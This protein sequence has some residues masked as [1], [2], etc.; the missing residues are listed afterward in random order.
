MSILWWLCEGPYPDIYSIS[1]LSWRLMEG[2]VIVVGGQEGLEVLIDS[3]W[4]TDMLA[5]FPRLF[6]VVSVEVVIC[7][8]IS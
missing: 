8:E 6:G 1:I 7:I 5:S 4:F 3:K 2:E